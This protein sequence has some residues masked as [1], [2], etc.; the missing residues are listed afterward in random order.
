MSE[1]T[2]AHC[3][4]VIIMQRRVHV[5]ISNFFYMHK[6]LELCCFSLQLHC[7]LFSSGTSS[8]S[9]SKESCQ[10]SD[11]NYYKVGNSFS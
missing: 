2:L 10:S 9:A 7:M 11:N 1:N 8:P 5:V 4:K 3:S 6:E